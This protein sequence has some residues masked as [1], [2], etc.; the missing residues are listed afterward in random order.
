M[1]GLTR[2]SLRNRL[3][4]ALISVAVLIFGVSSVLSLKQELMPDIQA[5]QAA[6]SVTYPGAAP[7]VVADEAA[8]PIQKAL[9]NVR[10]VTDVK[11]TSQTGG[12]QL[13][14]QWDY[15]LDTDK[16]IADLTSAV[17]G[18]KS[19]LPE[20]VKTE[21]AAGSIDDFPVIQLAVAA[22]LKL[23]ELT[24]LV[25]DLVVDRLAAIPGVR[26]VQLS[27][28]DT[29]QIAVTLRPHDLR[30]HDLQP[31]VVNQALQGQLSATP[32]GSTHDG[33]TQLSVQVGDAPDSIKQVSGLPV[34]TTDG[35]IPLSKIADVKLATVER[36]S[37]A[38]ADGRPALSVAV[39]KAPDA[40]TV[41]I[42]HAVQAA[43]PDAMSRIGHQAV[44]ST[45]FDQAPM[46]EQSLHD[47]AT[48]GGLGLAFAIVVIL[49]FLLSIRS[50]IITAISIPM[51]LLIAMIG[52]RIGDLSL[53]MLTLAA[54]TVAVGRVVDDSIV[55]IENIK[56]RGAGAARLSIGGVVD[57]VKEVAGAVTASTLT[58]VAVFV[59]LAVVGGPTGELFR[60]FAITVAV[61]L[62][63]SL[64][65]A[66]TIVPLLAYWF[67]RGRKLAA[68]AGAH[69][70]E[71]E[72]TKITALQRGYLPILRW[73]LKRPVITLVLS[74]LIFIGTVAATPLLKTD[75]L[76]SF[77]DDRSL[78][79]SQELP[80]GTRL[81]ATSRAAEKVERVL[82]DDPDIKSHLSTIGGQESN[83]ATFAVTLSDEADA[84]AATDRL[85]GKLAAVRNAGDVTLSSAV[86]AAS[87]N[88]VTVILSGENS[89]VLNDTVPAVV[90]AVK[91]V[92]G[93]SDV[94]S[95]LSEQRPIL[96]VSLNRMRAAEQGYTQ[97]EIGQ[98]LTAAMQGTT[99][100]QVSLDG[101]ERDLIVRT[102][103][104]NPT[105]AEI[106]AL[107]LPVSQA[108]QTEATEAAKD[109][110]QK[111]SDEL[112]ERSDAL[113]DRQ[114]ELADRQQ[115][116]ADRTQRQS[117]A[118]VRD[119]AD[120]L[121]KS[122]REAERNLEKTRAQLRKLKQQQPAAPKQPQPGQPQVP[123]TQDQLAAQQAA[124]AWAQQVA[125]LQ[126]AVQQAKAGVEQLDDQA[127]AMRDQQDEAAAQQD[128]ADQLKQDQEDLADQQEALGKEQK[129][130]AKKQEQLTD[131][132]ADPLTVGDVA[133]V[134]TVDAPTA[135]SQIDGKR[136]IT[137]T[138]TPT[139]SDL[140]AVSQALQTTVD[141]L[142][143]PAG[144]SVEQGGASADQQ[145][146]FGQL[147]LAMGLAVMLIFII[148]VATFRSLLQPLILL[149]S[150]P[151]AATG[152]LI[153]LLI[154]DTPLGV[155][156]M[157]G[158]LM[159]IG[160]VVTNAIVLIDLINTIRS[161]GAAPEQAIVDGARLRIRPIIMT[162]AATIFALLPMGL[163]FTGGG[164]FI[165]GP[166]AV[167]VIGGL[168]SSTLLTLILVPVLYSLTTRIGNRRR[169]VADGDQPRPDDQPEATSAD[170]NETGLGIIAD[171][172]EESRP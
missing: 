89:E 111:Q 93:L 54:L 30:A 100:G 32:A 15:G 3:V 59:P 38:R 29:D 123:V 1:S 44:A 11:A 41:E 52:L 130:L 12:A 138:A 39:L 148:M 43:L 135:V 58:T 129:K 117:E 106:E 45:A 34:A 57:S 53:N 26:D 10:G 51:S 50:T 145:E 85:R 7:D 23:P 133:T 78:Q 167:V 84:A 105:P 128:D 40:D 48:E 95:D 73:T 96:K 71:D 61:A 36:T 150:I 83:T 149:V 31:D 70:G 161:R 157:I 90:A 143:L 109:K 17:D 56:R 19:E 65:V 35:P 107:T 165:S 16:I 79:I 125:Q 60:P 104:P 27:G 22:D 62:L 158:L 13:T 49:V 134:K 156:A 28:Q 14:A 20:A 42:S 132:R 21:V 171:G 47:L 141:G 108:R 154:T 127:N 131:L 110:L 72:A 92:P 9:K 136:A 122:R 67:F 153:S 121:R 172:S 152:A 99:I 46:I 115:E 120:D 66:L 25:D 77:G 6:I 137:I 102:H 151:F 80:A 164:A 69:R 98:A 160:I 76:G 24:P 97:A 2:F 118:K 116:A 87:S 18:V 4:V 147:A 144:V 114:Q 139:G 82:A 168:V 68:G 169:S 162:A 75:F 166:L 163:G 8:D 63:A 101:V 113:Q 55:V 155:P 5:P 86:A 112:T 37:L 146:A 103:A 159:L 124:A 119:Q 126:A 170:E 94:R 140:G 91:K 74:V 64:L 81:A 142:E 33:N 88:D